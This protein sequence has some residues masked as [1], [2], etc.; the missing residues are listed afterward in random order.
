[1]KNKI[2]TAIVA[3]IY[4]AAIVVFAG[5]LISLSAKTTLRIMDNS[6]DYAQTES[7]IEKLVRKNTLQLG[8][9][10]GAGLALVG[11]VAM[12]GRAEDDRKKEQNR[13]AQIAA[14]QDKKIKDKEEMFASLEDLGNGMEDIAVTAQEL[15]TG[16]DKIVSSVEQMDSM[17]EEVVSAVKNIADN[18]KEGASL[19]ND[20]CERSGRDAAEVSEIEKL[21]SQVLRIMAETNQLSLEAAIKAG[22]AGEMGKEFAGVA[23]EIRR[24]AT[25]SEKN[26]W[27]IQKIA[28][29][30]IISADELAEYA[31]KFLAYVDSNRERSGGQELSGTA[32]DSSAEELL[33]S[34]SGI[35]NSV[36]GVAIKAKA[37]AKDT[38]HMT[39][40]VQSATEQCKKIAENMAVENNLM[41]SLHSDE[42]RPMSALER[43]ARKR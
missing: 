39:E 22:R 16:M 25:E 38:L 27:Q 2:L 20:I 19:V 34:M 33:S 26:V 40:Q 29:K 8:L 37:R 10:A 31:K 30:V 43:Y 17:S 32:M 11:I 4:T 14:E 6:T 21:A 23:E 15:I 9:A 36:E 18:A 12:T 7:Y 35:M 5:Y 42:A 3:V 24:L 13:K 41:D 28:K 1:M